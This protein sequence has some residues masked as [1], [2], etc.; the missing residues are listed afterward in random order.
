MINTK[1]KN[2]FLVTVV[3]TSWHYKK[4]L[5]VTINQFSTCARTAVT[6][7]HP[8]PPLLAGRLVAKPLITTLTRTAD[9]SRGPQ[10]P[11]TRYSWT[12]CLL[13]LTLAW[14]LID[15]AN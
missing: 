11:L 8:P 2:L 14:L 4:I 5:C 13:R 10:C 7:T 1:N 6:V 9:L 12:A 3:I 15:Q